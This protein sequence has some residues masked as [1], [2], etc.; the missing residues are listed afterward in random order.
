VLTLTS[1]DYE[2]ACIL[3]GP[4]LLEPAVAALK[5][6]QGG[7]ATAVLRDPMCARQIALAAACAKRDRVTVMS[8]STSLAATA[9]WLR[10]HPTAAGINRADALA[11]EARAWRRAEREVARLQPSLFHE[12]FFSAEAE[13]VRGVSVRD[14]PNNDDARAAW[15]GIVS[16]RAG[17]LGVLSDAELA[18]TARQYPQEAAAATGRDMNELRQFPLSRDAIADLRRAWAN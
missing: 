4:E 6:Q 14:E 1:T 8:A 16:E 3:Y 2:K 10:D 17:R 13:A 5:S 9:C 7:S 11:G 12:R 15:R 18:V